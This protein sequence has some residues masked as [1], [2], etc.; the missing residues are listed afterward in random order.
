MLPLV[1]SGALFSEEHRR[2]REQRKV[3]GTTSIASLCRKF[4]KMLVGWYHS[5]REFDA[6]RMRTCESQFRVAA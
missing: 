4:L 6:T 1:K 5:G 3:S 2:N